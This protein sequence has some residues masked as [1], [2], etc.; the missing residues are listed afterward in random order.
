MEAPSAYI[1]MDRQWA[2]ARGESLPD[3]IS[4]TAL[5]ADISGFTPLTDALLQAL[6][7]RRGTD[8]LTRHLNQVYDALI[9]QVHTYRGSVINF[10]GDAITCWFDDTPA[11]HFPGGVTGPAELRATACSLAMQQAMH[12]FAVLKQPGGGAVSLSLKV[13]TAS[14]W[15]RRFLV[16]D[17]HIQ[18][19]DVLA[20]VVL[21]RIGTAEHYARKGEVLLSQELATQLGDQVNIVEWRGKTKSQKQ[22]SN[23]ATFGLVN[24]LT[25]PVEPCPWPAAPGS[26]NQ[27]GNGGLSEAQIRPW[28]LPPIYQSLQSGQGEFL[29]E[30]R[31]AVALFLRFEGLDYD[32]DEDAGK[33]LDAFIRWVQNVLVGYDSYVMQVLVD[34]K[35]SHLY[36]IFGAPVA[37]DDDSERAV[38]AALEL[39]AAPKQFDF[40][41][42]IQMGINQGRMRTGAYGSS[43]RR[44]YGVL[45]DGVNVAARLMSQAAPGQILV[46]QSIVEAAS[47]GYY[48]K[49]LGPVKFKGKPEP[50][51]VSVVLSPRPPSPQR[52]FTIFKDTLV[53]RSEQLDQLEHILAD[54]LAGQ[55]QVVWL[56]GVTGIGKSHLVAEFAERA[57]R[58]GVRVVIGACQSS[59]QTVTYYPWQQIFRSL[60]GLIDERT[61]QVNQEARLAR[62]INQLEALIRRMNPDWLIRLPLLGDLLALLIL[63]NPTTAAFPP[64]VRQNA[65]F[66]LVEEMLQS[67]AQ[68][69]PLLVLIEDAHWLDEASQALLLSLSR[70]QLKAPIL[71]ILVQNLP[72]IRAE[73]E[74]LWL[75]LKRLPQVHPVKLDE[76]SPSEI[77]ELV[78]R[79][80]QGEISPLA[81]EL[82]QIQAQGNP[83]FTKELV[84]ALQE[85]G[86]LCRRDDGQWWLSEW[87]FNA[88]QQ[89]NCLV[90]RQGQW[91]LIENASLAAAEVDLPDSIHSIV[92]AR[93]DRLAEPLKVTLK[94]A[95]VIGRLFEL[96][97][98]VHAHPAQPGQAALLEQFSQLQAL[99]FI[100]PEPALPHR[101][102]L[103]KHNVTHEVTY[104]TLLEQQERGLHQAVAEALE[105]WQPEAVER[106]A[107]HFSHT[108]AQDKMLYYLDLAAG[109]A[110]HEYANETALTYYTQALAVTERWRWRKGQVETL[111]TLG[112]REE[113]KSSLQMLATN[114]ETPTFEVGYLWGQYYE[115]T[116]NYA[117]AQ[118]AIELALADSRDKKDLINEMRCL[119]HLGLIAR[120]QG[121]YD[122][123]KTW[124]GQALALFEHTRIYSEREAWVVTQAFN[125]LGA[126]YRQQ[127][128]FDQAQTYHERALAL[129]RQT[130]NRAEEAQACNDL[131]VSFFYQRRLVKAQ[132]YHQQALEIRQAI[133][134]RAG[135]GMSLANLAEVTFIMGDY[136]QTQKYLTEGLNIFQA[137]GN[138]WDEANV[139]NTLGILYQE[140]GDLT[141][142]EACLKQ[143][144]AL[145]Q[146]IGDQA[147]QAYILVN[148]GLV[149]RD[150]GELELAKKLLMTGL[151]LAEAQDDQYLMSSFLNYLSTVHLQLGKL[152]EAITQAELSLTLRRDAKMHLATP[153]NLATLAAAYLAAG[154]LAQALAYA[155]Q[156]QAVL[157][158]CGGEGPEFPQQDYFIIYQVFT[159]AGQRQYAQAALQAAYELVMARA[160]KII[161]AA[162]RQSYLEQVAINRTIVTR[163][164]TLKPE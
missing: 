133:G 160:A 96:D 51:P 73:Q 138:R 127:G 100:Q 88:L 72:I 99:D 125:G 110:Q 16:G 35:G 94:A 53:G 17:P 87:I 140:L 97:L 42:Q 122:Q 144:L 28:L 162:L 4:G 38:G 74:R 118:A 24:S 46:S 27:A 121:N 34:D 61:S 80:L 67:W 5:F 40:I 98:L 7:T 105:R 114:L 107:Y 111:H 95:S 43:T 71:F 82:I 152:D 120:R 134:D 130:G 9:Q 32:H 92:L 151:A 10:S 113:E 56:E 68:E 44:T 15:V 75:E 11:T 79:R 47:A 103:F 60:L 119:S 159:A 158:G 36:A 30:I 45:G 102:Y 59:S 49:F 137:T 109:K 148:L 63:D 112:R 25:V 1:P 164:E 106:L 20:G 57:L 64:Q 143:G 58:R 2:I 84:D 39:Q 6:G 142:A 52:L 155:G 129:S 76:L 123:A 116:G 23:T 145:T 86:D 65:L 108:D 90:K 136:G 89:A 31:P 146:E 55:K 19:I 135:E 13:S 81:L 104:A 62:Q 163:Y 154:N 3:R 161:D 12:Q 124:Y 69:Q 139:W 8:E 70:V 132:V 126:V 14:G 37:H 66:D 83:L 128:G 91:S 147:G 50:I 93:L 117:R 78:T 48:F 141:Q 131:G 33:K 26:T 85:A 149:T 101:T 22:R 41:T 77:T 115:A 54:T 153:D 150:K 21:E 156:T 157:E 29:A 18:C